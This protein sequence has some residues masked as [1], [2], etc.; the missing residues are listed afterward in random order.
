MYCL[1]SIQS[2]RNRKD[3][4]YLEKQQRTYIMGVEEIVARILFYLKN[5]VLCH[6]C[7]RQTSLNILI[8]ECVLEFPL[9]C[10]AVWNF[11][12]SESTIEKEGK[13]NI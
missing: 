7:L 13:S 10:L 1:A 9:M 6:L 12:C 3:L 2:D 5:H 11:Y 4:E 8:T